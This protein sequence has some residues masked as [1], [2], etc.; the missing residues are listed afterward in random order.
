MNPIP[1]ELRGFATFMLIFPTLLLVLAT[2]LVDSVT[3]VLITVVIGA[4]VTLTAA[5]HGGLDKPVIG[6]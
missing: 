3:R 4:S 1:L 6:T 2:V 5:M